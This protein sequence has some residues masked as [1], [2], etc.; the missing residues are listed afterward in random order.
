MNKNQLEFFMTESEVLA[1]RLGIIQ[2]HLGCGDGLSCRL[3]SRKKERTSAAVAGE[4]LLS[5]IWV[6]TYDALGSSAIFLWRIIKT[7]RVDTPSGMRLH[8]ID[9]RSCHRLRVKVVK[10]T[11]KTQM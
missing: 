3:S 4:V 9:R 5:W 6:R 8:R 7:M 1:I 11:S 2:C 10:F